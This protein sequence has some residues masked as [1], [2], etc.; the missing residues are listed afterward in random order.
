MCYINNYPQ[1][2][3]LLDYRPAKI[4]KVP[5]Q[6]ITVLQ[7]HQVSLCKK[8]AVGAIILHPIVNK[9][10]DFPIYLLGSALLF[11]SQKNTK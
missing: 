8:N 1:L 10:A 2:I 7:T 4:R 11:Q 6:N 9:F 3:I 5:P